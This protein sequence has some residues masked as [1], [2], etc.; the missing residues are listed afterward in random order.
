MEMTIQAFSLASKRLKSGQSSSYFIDLNE[1]KNVD[2]QIHQISDKS[3]KPKACIACG[4]E[5]LTITTS[6]KHN[7]WDL[8]SHS[9]GRILHHEQVRR[10]CKKC[11]EQ[12]RML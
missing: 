1:I 11:G 5:K 8:S 9:V 3:I 7:L 2:I 10:E 4:H 12:F 6:T